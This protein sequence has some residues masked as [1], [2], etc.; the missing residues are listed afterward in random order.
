M[1]YISL[2]NILISTA[3]VMSIF[4]HACRSKAEYKNESYSRKIL[5]DKRAESFYRADQYLK[6]KLCYDTLLLVDSLNS[7]YYFKRGYCNSLLLTN[8]KEA[9]SDYIK[10]I[11]YGYKNKKASYLSLGIIYRSNKS[12]DTAM[13]FYQKALEVDPNYVKAKNEISEVLEILKGTK[14]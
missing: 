13:F 2:T 10:S 8:D 3:I 5:L 1:I 14:N 12:Y 11:L 6:A 4:I 9:I 7:E